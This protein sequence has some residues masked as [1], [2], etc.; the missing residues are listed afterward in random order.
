MV[1]LAVVSLFGAIP[2]H[3]MVI[4]SQRFGTWTQT[5]FPQIPPLCAENEAHIPWTKNWAENW[6]PQKLLQQFHI[7]MMAMQGFQPIL[8]FDLKQE[9]ILPQGPLDQHPEI[10]TP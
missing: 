1:L 6:T 5:A 10:S 7:K 4:S 2:G 9:A 3:R 8:P